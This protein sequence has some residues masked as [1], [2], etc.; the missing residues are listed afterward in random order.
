MT[1]A[2]RDTGRRGLVELDDR[3][4]LATFFARD[5]A[6]HIYELGDLD[7]FFWP[8]TRWYGWRDAGELQ[9]VALLYTGAGEPT[10]LLLDRGNAA[11]ARALLAASC[12]RLPASVYAHLSPGLASSV[13]GFA[14]TPHGRHLKMVLATPQRALEACADAAV[15][16]GPSDAAELGAFYAASYPG[17]WFVSRMLETGQYFA[18]RERGRLVAV[19]GVHVYSPEYGVAALGNI[20][21]A[22]DLR[23]R[24]LGRLVTARVC[25][26]LLETATTIG[27]NVHADNAP[28]I[29]CYRGLG[30]EVVA[31]YDELGLA[32]G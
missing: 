23:G 21:T 5:P 11:A 28:A 27:L 20:T 26:S 15:R 9:A 25:Q 32:R 19:A 30:F 8:Y 29:R 16:L 13:R 10:L 12:A 31:E 6:L 17:N 2:D 22:P 7:P 18:V 1:T 4:E 14:V 24:G 3:H